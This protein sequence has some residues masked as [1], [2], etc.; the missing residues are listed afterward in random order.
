MATE[1]NKTLQYIFPQ[2]ANKPP[3]GME[4]PQAEKPW[5]AAGNTL[6]GRK[7][8][9]VG[10]RGRRRDVFYDPRV[11][12]Q[13]ARSGASDLELI[14]EIMTPRSSIVVNDPSGWLNG[15]AEREFQQYFNRTPEQEANYARRKKE[16]EAGSMAA[17]NPQA[18]RQVVDVARQNQEAMNMIF[19]KA[20]QGQHKLSSDIAEY[21]MAGG[22]TQRVLDGRYGTGSA[23][24][25]PQQPQAKA[26]TAEWNSWSIPSAGGEM[27]PPAT[28]NEFVGPPN[29]GVFTGPPNL[30][31]PQGPQNFGEVTGPMQDMQGPPDWAN[32][33]A[34]DYQP[35]PQN[36]ANNIRTIAGR[37]DDAVSRAMQVFNPFMTFSTLKQGGESALPDIF[38]SQPTYPN[39]IS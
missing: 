39:A 5:W 2:A 3:A 29:L 35:L 23:T 22:G 10:K 33:S 36:E 18:G 20:P 15:G 26:P 13:P 16:L 21:P 1:L 37:G 28:S 34:W 25:Q 32:A 19:P 17:M 27:P 4:Q 38:G 8:K 11:G 6:S 9:K 30:G 14:R 12:P 7:A 24:I 31:V